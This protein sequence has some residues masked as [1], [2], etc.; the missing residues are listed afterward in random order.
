LKNLLLLIVLLVIVS[1]IAAAPTPIPRF[2]WEG[3]LSYAALGFFEFNHSELPEVGIPLII[4]QINSPGGIGEVVS[5]LNRLIEET[6]VPVVLWT[7]RGKSLLAD[8]ALLLAWEADYC[9]I[10]SGSVFGVQH[11]YYL[12]AAGELVRLQDGLPPARLANGSTASDTAQLLT[13]GFMSLTAEGLLAHEL[14][15]GLVNDSS[16]L[17]NQLTEEGL[18]DESK[19]YQIATTERDLLWQII[20]ILSEPSVA[21]V[22]FLL[23]LLSFSFAGTTPRTT[24]A[25]IFGAAILLLALIAL[26]LLPITT[27]GL[28]LVIGAMVAFTLELLLDTGGLFLVAGMAL[29]FFGGVNF[30]RPET[31]VVSPA[32]LVPTLAIIGVLFGFSIRSRVLSRFFGKE[33]DPAKLIGQ[34]GVVISPLDARRRGRIL[35]HGE[36]WWGRSTKALH[37]GQAVRVLNLTGRTFEVEAATRCVASQTRD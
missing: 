2:S 10:G 15:D 17:L 21:F 26:T 8:E 31:V 3:E 4:W 9:Y 35:L 36:L 32:T 11:D 1:S 37:R 23:A 18:L 28:L 25:L 5:S 34:T 16:A 14:V 20:E 24:F 6:P 33:P 30:Y 27:L 13:A 7:G 29:L 12:N 22:L 19:D